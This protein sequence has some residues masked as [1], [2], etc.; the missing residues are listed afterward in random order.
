[1]TIRE[2]IKQHFKIQFKLDEKRRTLTFNVI[3]ATDADYDDLKAIWKETYLN[4]Y[5]AVK[6]LERYYTEKLMSSEYF[7]G[8]MA[9]VLNSYQYQFAD[10]ATFTQAVQ[11]LNA[12]LGEYEVQR[13][14]RD[15]GTPDSIFM[16]INKLED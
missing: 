14:I 15:V 11:E 8:R 4:P 10:M 6:N 5:R 16:M 1:M 13:I 2:W 12:L 3:N 7:A 9:S